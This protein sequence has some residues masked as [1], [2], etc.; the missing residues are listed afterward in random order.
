M[1]EKIS[2]EDF[3]KLD[4]R[5]G[6]VIEAE[7]I[8]G[9]EKLLALKISLGD[10]NQKIIAGIGTKYAPDDIVG[11]Q[12]IIIA[13][14]EPRKLMGHTSEGMLLAGGEDKPIILI[15]EDSLPDGSI[16]H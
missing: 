3:T 12:V 15:P 6:T 14:L 2:Y 11:K 13:N 4:L 1:K 9:S 8:E 7:K 5:A 10:N 16:I